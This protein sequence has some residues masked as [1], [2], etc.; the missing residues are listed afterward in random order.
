MP[1][2]WS[3][4][5]QV[6]FNLS[7]L[8]LSSLPQH[9]N[10]LTSFAY[11]LRSLTSSLIYSQHCIGQLW[12]A[13][14]AYLSNPFKNCCFIA[15]VWYFLQNLHIDFKSWAVIL[16]HVLLYNQGQVINRMQL[17]WK[18]KNKS[19]TWRASLTV[20]YGGKIKT[21]SDFIQKLGAN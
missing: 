4:G 18:T 2:I 10:N 5:S 15:G 13:A 14:D 19:L 21:I 3:W 1:W 20:G 12:I 6:A 11:S 16:P 9:K 17:R 8:F 7:Q